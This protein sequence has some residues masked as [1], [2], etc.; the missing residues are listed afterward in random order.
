MIR[1]GDAGRRSQGGFRDMSSKKLA[2]GL[3]ALIVVLGGGALG[4]EFAVQAWMA[5]QVDAALAQ[6]AVT[7]ASHGAVRYS[8]WRRHLE[9]DDLAVETAFPELRSAHAQHIAIDGVSP[10]GMAAGGDL[11]VPAVAARGLEVTSDTLHQSFGSLSLGDVWLPGGLAVD[12]ALPREQLIGSI[13][14][15]LSV[16]HIEAQDAREWTDQ[17]SHDVSF[18]TFVAEDVDKGRIAGITG[19]K[20]VSLSTLPAQ[21]METRRTEVAELHLAGVGFAGWR[22]AFD[23]IAAGDGSPMAAFKHLSVDRLDAVGVTGTFSDHGG[24]KISIARL[25]LDKVAP[26]SLGA[27]ELEDFVYAAPQASFRLRSLRLDGLAY[28]LG[29]GPVAMPLLFVHRLDLDDLAAGAKAGAEIGVKE[30]LVTMSGSLGKATGMTV[31]VSTVTIP[32]TAAPPLL[33]V[34]YN[35]LV[36]DYEAQSS[37][38]AAQGSITSTQH[39]TARGAGEI[40]LSLRMSNYP[41]VFDAHDVLSLMTRLSEARL[42]HFELRYD[43]ASLVERL[44]KFDAMKTQ[45]SVEAVREGFIAQVAAER[46]AFAEKP[47]MSASLDAIIAF[48]RQPASLTLTLAPPQPLSFGTLTGLSKREPDAAFEMLGASIH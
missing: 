43:D 29:D 35:E 37:Y 23:P 38:D 11:I 48:L 44:I 6:P 31:K 42:D 26:G 22:R 9:I 13:L 21:P 12:A 15:R 10:F 16:R 17:H 28:E 2:I 24:R 14:D 34:G 3:A 33:L 18:A 8:L 32:A 27:L 41:A 30:M 5:R 19:T 45:R 47:A 1:A 4:A 46:S 40:K 25:G 36:M 39:L 20:M 7:K